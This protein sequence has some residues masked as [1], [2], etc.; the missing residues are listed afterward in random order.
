MSSKEKNSEFSFEQ[1]MPI[2]AAAREN[3]VIPM[4]AIARRTLL[5]GG[6]AVGASLLLVKWLKRIVLRQWSG[7]T[8]LWRSP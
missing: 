4:P 3:H 6:T 7:L 1:E 8:L 5:V 2:I